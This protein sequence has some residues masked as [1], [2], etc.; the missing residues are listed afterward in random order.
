MGGYT[1]TRATSSDTSH[2]AAASADA[3]ADTCGRAEEGRRSVRGDGDSPAP[4]VIY[5]QTQSTYTHARART[6]PQHPPTGALA[7]RGTTAASTSGPHR[8]AAP[9]RKQAPTTHT[10]RSTG[11]DGARV[12]SVRRVTQL[13]HRSCL[14]KSHSVAQPRNTGPRLSTSTNGGLGMGDGAQTASHSPRTY[15]GRDRC[16]EGGGVGDGGG[17]GAVTGAGRKASSGGGGGGCCCS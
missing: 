8:C 2:V 12:Q 17:R 16:A 11:L 13:D 9:T 6:H 14:R 5:S 4:T 15:R 10:G 1:R 7:N 3:D